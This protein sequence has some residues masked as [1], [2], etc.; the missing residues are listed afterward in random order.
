MKRLYIFLSLILLLG[1][2][3]THSQ[4]GWFW[5]NPLPQGNWLTDVEFT[6]SN[7]VYVSGYGGTMM[8]STN[9]GVTFSV[10][11]NN[12]CG[13]SIVFIN[14]LTGFSNSTNGI[15]KTTNG[16]NNWRFITAPVD[17]VLGYY[18]NTLLYGIKNDKVFLSRDLGVNWNLSLTAST[19]EYLSYV[20]FVDENTGYCSGFKTNTCSIYK[21]TNSGLNWNSVNTGLKYSIPNMYFF[22]EQRGLAL[23]LSSRSLLIKTNNGCLNWDTILTIP[24]NSKKIIFFDNITGY[25]KGTNFIINTTNQ[26]INWSTFST[27]H[28]TFLRNINEGIGIDNFKRNYFYRTTDRGS[29]WNAMTSGINDNFTSITFLD[30]VTGFISGTNKIFKTTNSGVNWSAYELGLDSSTSPFVNELTFVNSNTGYAAIN[31]GKIAKTTNCGLNW[32]IYYIGQNYSLPVLSF[33]SADTGY[34]ISYGGLLYSTTTGGIDWIFL[35]RLEDGAFYD[36]KFIN[37]NTG[38]AGASGSYGSKGKILKTTNRGYNWSVT[39]LDSIMVI[40]EIICPSANDV[41][42]VGYK[43]DDR[44]VIYRSTNNGANWSYNIVPTSIYSVHFPT[45]VTGYAASSNNSFYKT[46]DSGNNWYQTFSINGNIIESIFFTDSLTGYGAGLYGQIIKTTTGGGV[47]ISVEPQSYVVPHTYNLYQ[48]YP[49]PFNPT[50]KIKFDIPKAMNASLKIYDILGRE[51][52]VIVNDF[53]IP[54][55]YAFDFSGSDLSSGVYFYVLTGEGFIE[56]KK[57][58]LVK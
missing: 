18:S 15:L 48:N 55:T 24:V 3:K 23:I 52:S 46:T 16:G 54:G 33:P 19:N 1:P 17:S 42:V 45:S 57:M 5:L 13:K 2:D 6:S 34:S 40:T 12:E 4:D 58:L 37:N 44:G 53:L 20:Y 30:Q 49:N 28:N 26:G 35:S 27:T 31:P 39:Q 14:E 32:N 47:L 36:I 41:F 56:S 29:T 25:I 51:I 21:T 7:I 22:D 38:F 11:S 43:Y 8:K 10:M 50:T 9:N